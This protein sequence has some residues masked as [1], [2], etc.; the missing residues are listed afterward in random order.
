MILSGPSKFIILMGDPVED[1][2]R[3]ISSI[4]CKVLLLLL[5]AHFWKAL[6]VLSHHL[7]QSIPYMYEKRMPILGHHFIIFKIEFYSVMCRY[8]FKTFTKVR[9]F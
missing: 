2:S 6:L 4:P 1:I 5:C 7:G 3:N 9:K 8:F